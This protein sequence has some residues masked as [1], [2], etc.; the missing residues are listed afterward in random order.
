MQTET[1]KKWMKNVSMAIILLHLA[2]CTSDNLEKMVPADATGVICI[3]VPE[4]LENAGMLKGGNIVLPKTLKQAIDEND[5]SPL[6]IL[7]ADLCLL[8]RQDVW[9]SPVG[10]TRRT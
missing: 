8:H 5:T 3:D 6:C 10:A 9:A 1:L 2:G 4:I 7:M